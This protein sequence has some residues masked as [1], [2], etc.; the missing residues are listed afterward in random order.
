MNT[1]FNF[2][3]FLKVLSNEWVLN[4]KKV[5]P[6]WGSIISISSALLVLQFYYAEDLINRI[7]IFV[8]SFIIGSIIQGFYLQYYFSEFSSKKKTQALLLLPASR[9]ETFWAKFTLGV[10]LYVIIAFCFTVALLEVSKIMNVWLW[11]NGVSEKHTAYYLAQH[12]DLINLEDT[13]ALLFIA[14]LCLLWMFSVAVFLL[15][16]VIFK[17]NAILKSFVFGV[18]IIAG[19]GYLVCTVYFLFTG[20]FPQFAI[21]G[22]IW[23]G[24][25]ENIQLYTMYPN[26]FIGAILFIVIALF[27][28][29]RVKYNEKTI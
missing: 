5:V 17:K 27:A 19:F 29:A 12:Q 22:V 11:E 14:M 1:T 24:N 21:P 23:I 6:L 25:N 3:R 28:I 20:V 18:A 16:V 9:N 10:V 8:L 13:N 7:N 26:L 15:G 2:N 4:W